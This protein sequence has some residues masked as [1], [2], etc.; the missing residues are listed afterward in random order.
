MYGVG[1]VEKYVRST[2]FKT[3]TNGRLRVEGVSN[4]MT[5]IL[6][7]LKTL[8]SHPHPDVLSK[9]IRAYFLP[10][11]RGCPRSKYIPDTDMVINW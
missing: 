6:T 4:A 11:R 3:H 5:D 2:F 1:T 10:C 7:A 8:P 9:R